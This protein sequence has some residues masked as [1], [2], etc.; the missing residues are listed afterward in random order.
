MTEETKTKTY[1][2]FVLPASVVSKVDLSRLIREIEWVDGELTSA[3]VRTKTGAEAPAAPNTSSTLQEFLAQNNLDLDNSLARTD[4]IKQ[5]RLLKDKV[6]VLHMTFAVPADSESLQQLSAYVRES[7]HPQ[8]VISVGLQPG[9]VAGVYLRTPNHVH[10]FSVRAKLHS[11]R[12]LL[13]KELE[14]LNGRG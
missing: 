3:S 1:A 4:L 11:S 2:D 12:G 5:L 6:P 9:L 13:I 8:A 7:I 10:D 14:A